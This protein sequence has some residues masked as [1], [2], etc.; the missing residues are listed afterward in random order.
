MLTNAAPPVE[1]AYHLND[2]PV[3]PVATKFATV[4]PLQNVC[5]TAVG[6]LVALIVTVVDVAIVQPVPLVAVAV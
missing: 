4:A 5:A 6:A 2:A 1:A 3:A